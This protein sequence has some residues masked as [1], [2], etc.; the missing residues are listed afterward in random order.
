MEY[1]DRVLGI[2]VINENDEFRH[3]LNFIVTRYHLQRVLM[4][5][6][7]VIFLYPKTELEQ[8]EVLI[9]HIS[10][11]QKNEDFPVVLI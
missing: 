1:L 11:I 5:G 6:H 3:L 8:I 7:R 2:E 10:R 9:K 4:D